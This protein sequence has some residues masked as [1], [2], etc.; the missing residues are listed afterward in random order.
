MKRYFQDI[1][2]PSS[3]EE[4]ESLIEK[5]HEPLDSNVILLP[6][7]KASIVSPFYSQALKGLD[8]KKVLF[9]APLH[10]E[11][12]TGCEEDALLTVPS[13][14]CDPNSAIQAPTLKCEE[15][16]LE[17]EYT[18]EIF[19]TFLSFLSSNVTVYPIFTS[20]QGKKDITT[21]EKYLSGLDA[22][23]IIV[24]GNFSDGNN[25]DEALK[26]ANLLL[27]LL[28]ENKSLIDEGN[29]KHIS[30]CAFPILEALRKRSKSFS[31]INARCS[32]G[33]IETSLKRAEGK[34]YQVFGVF[35]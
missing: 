29:R 20:L 21:L 31:L 26:H 23:V 11:R 10:N 19:M 14:T 4:F 35:R 22:D 24:S 18:L 25:N 13:F 12:F 7:A 1:M 27:S 2:Y 32:G 9:I 3:K 28:E 30:G 17:E 34:V 6:H 15:Y 16:I 5:D 8:N 33:E